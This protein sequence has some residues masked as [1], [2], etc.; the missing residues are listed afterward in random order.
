MT[1]STPN[2]QTVVALLRDLA[3][4]DIRLSLQGDKLRCS[5]PD[6]VLTDELRA[7]IAN[8]KPEIVAALRQGAAT[9]DDG[10]VLQKAPRDEPLPLSFAQQRLWFLHKL[11]PDDPVYNLTIDLPLPD[12]P[13]VDALERALGEMAKRHEIL[14]V[15]FQDI[16]GIPTQVI[17]DVL[18]RLRVVDAQGA[19]EASRAR[20]TAELVQAEAQRPFDLDAAPPVRATLIRA[21]AGTHLIVVLHHVLGDGWSMGLIVQELKAL[22]EAEIGQR[23]SGLP[24]LA[25]QYVDYA[26]STRS[27][28]DRTDQGA[29][30]AYWRAKLSSDH[31]P[32]ELPID[33][34]RPKELGSRGAI[35][36]FRFPPA[37]AQGLRAL[38]RDSHVTLFATLLAAYEILLHRYTGRSSIVL[39]TPVANR[40]TVELEAMIGLF[41]NTVVMRGDLAGDPTVREL[42]VRTRN[43]W[44]EANEHGDYPFEKIV[45]LVRP[46]RHMTHSP[47][48]QTSFILQNTPGIG[49]YGAISAGAVFE[50]SL[51]VWDVGEDLAASFEYNRDLFEPDTIARMAGHLLTL[52]EAMVAGPDTAI[53]TLPLLTPAESRQLLVEWN[54]TDALPLATE[55]VQSG[56]ERQVVRNPDGVAVRFE[57]AALTYR[58]LDEAAN[59]LA[60]HLIALGVGAEV[61]VGI[62]LERSTDV[63]VAVLGVLKAGGAYVPIDPAFPQARIEFIAE[64]AGLH[65]LITTKAT[66][67]AIGAPR[68]AVLDLDRDRDDIASRLRT[69]PTTTPAPRDAAYVL[70][71]SGSTGKPKGTVVEHAGVSNYLRWMCDTFPLEPGEPV[72]HTTSFAFDISVRELF[73]P[74]S[75]GAEIIL[76]PGEA[77]ADPAALADLVVEHGAV[78]VRFVPPMLSFFLEEPQFA[79]CGTLRWIFCGGEAMPSALQSRFFA[80]CDET[81]LNA[82]L[83]NTYGPTET[84]INVTAWTCDRVERGPTAPIGRPLANT[85]VYVLDEQRLPVP[86]GVRGELY[87]GGAPVAR[88]Y[89]GRPE[90][91]AERF[92][93]DLFSSDPTDRIYR[94]GDLVRW[95]GEGV[96]EFLGRND[97]QL[98]I[99]GRRIEPG[100][101]ESVLWAHPG[102]AAAAVLPRRDPGGSIRLIAYVSPRED[103]PVSTPD[104][105]EDL[106]QQLPE[107]MVPDAF[108]WVDTLPL[109]ANGKLDRSALPEPDALEGPAGSFVPPANALEATVADI[110]RGLLGAARVGVEDNFFDL[111]GHSLLV[112][113]LQRRLK[114]AT[115][116][117][118]T[119]A[120][121]FRH[122]TVRATVEHI[123]ASRGPDDAASPSSGKEAM[124]EASATRTRSSCV[125]SIQPTGRMPTIFVVPGLSGEILSYGPLAR[126]LGE[127]QPLYGLRSV[128]IDGDEEPLDRVEDIAARFVADIRAMQPSGPY[129]IVGVCI[130]GLIAF[131][132]AQ[133]LVTEGERVA[134]LTLVETWSP[135]TH[136]RIR[137]RSPL[138][139]VVGFVTGRVT[140]HMEHLRGRSFRDKLTYLRS[141]MHVVGQIATTGDVYRGDQSARARDL[142]MARNGYAAAHYQPRA[143][144]GRVAIVICSDRPTPA[145]DPRLI[146]RDLATEECPI[147]EIGAQ[148]SGGVLQVPHVQHLAEALRTWMAEA[149]GKFV[150]TSA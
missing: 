106:R 53:S 11:N 55:P 79:K 30:E 141:K 20:A 59:R 138:A 24:D 2:G 46:D 92:L 103:H 144:R 88:G 118:L 117:E 120:D 17:T 41:V 64:D 143:Y 73:W 75:S 36:A 90:M 89:L 109:T 82:A 51:F 145:P 70:Y 119:V 42:L 116:C 81:G 18:P 150:G 45:D 69:L 131:E 61:R 8:R 39:G 10:P 25:W 5:A 22:Y 14:R 56:F 115:G 33:R 12:L 29:N 148:D 50:L 68:C 99:R 26:Y 23:P 63:A 139:A 38:S 40:P 65:V 136:R 19:D 111:G 125:A 7:L 140:R 6:G 97:N 114:A 34:P 57:D 66:N 43:E 58:E 122:Q 95:R 132:L 86:I 105:R 27:H 80:R 91:T 4:K 76:A 71:T 102:I 3:N 135:S 54:D 147:L 123:V 124:S 62:C 93:P 83:V 44:L 15:V 146:W 96:L 1:V 113:Q 16:E 47:L 107:H 84:T 48:F 94:T 101:V 37:V 126:A 78:S 108:V 74:L 13:D 130:G 87:V 32:M 128:G 28:F 35:H 129:H 52:A 21:G 110:W 104:L 9:V 100:E 134:L 112:I 98:K 142:V 149:V 137:Q 133:Q 121:L 60:H 77:L 127:D 67:S 31:A 49:T 72:L 85:R